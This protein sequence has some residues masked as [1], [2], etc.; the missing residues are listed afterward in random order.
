VAEWSLLIDIGTQPADESNGPLSGSCDRC[1]DEGFT[2][3]HLDAAIAWI[4]I[5]DAPEHDAVR[6]ADVVVRL[7]ACVA[8][9]LRVEEFYGASFRSTI[10]LLLSEEIDTAIGF[11]PT[12][13]VIIDA[14][15]VPNVEDTP[16]VR[17]AISQHFAG[18]ALE[19]GDVVRFL[20]PLVWLAQREVAKVVATE[21]ESEKVAGS[22]GF[23][24][25]LATQFTQLI[26]LGIKGGGVLVVAVCG[27]DV[28]ACELRKYRVRI[29][30][31]L[32]HDPTEPLIDRGEIEAAARAF[33]GLEKVSRVDGLIA[34][35][36]VMLE[37]FVARFRMTQAAEN[38]QFCE[39]QIRN[40][41]AM[42]R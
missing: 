9:I 36:G 14:G 26:G 4:D 11:E 34:L 12:P 41:G 13:E 37:K 5:N 24:T 10:G 32:A 22:E 30:D 42:V 31:L 7:D 3:A 20:F 38:P 39:V 16:S 8:W 6:R 19:N 35:I 27:I 21:V 15:F 25:G 40:T 17:C 2:H 33:E 1:I 29:G 18:G 23:F 28:E